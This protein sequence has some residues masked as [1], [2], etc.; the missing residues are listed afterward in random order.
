MTSLK[1]R[2]FRTGPTLWDKEDVTHYQELLKTNPEWKAEFDRLKEWGDQ[3]IRQPLDVPTHAIE[4]DGSWAFPGFQRGYKNS[5]GKW[6]WKWKLMSTLLKR[7]KDSATLGILYQLSGDRKYADYSKQIL[8][9]LVDAYGYQQQNPP[10]NMSGQD[11]F[12]PYGFDGADSSEFLT[13]ACNGY[14]LIYNLPT[15]SKQDREQIEGKL[16]RPLAERLNQ[17]NLKRPCSHS[18]W[19]P[20]GLY[21]VFI[22]GMVLNDPKL[23]ND[24]LYGQGGS[25]EKVG[26][27]LV[28]CFNPSDVKDDGH[29][30]QGT[31]L[32]DQLL[33]LTVMVRVAEVMW[34]RGVDL[35][36]YQSFAL[37]RLFDYPLKSDSQDPLDA[38]M[39]GADMAALLKVSGVNTYEYAFR[40]YRDPRYLSI[41]GKLPK[42]I[43]FDKWSYLPSLFDSPSR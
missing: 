6:I 39:I 10:A 23:A 26:D 17:G 40:R 3:R 37:K 2:S 32:D 8:L 25:M 15:I 11:H 16:I 29:W 36:S 1:P 14:D 42:N 34:H 43:T 13:Q 21:G 4:T 7:V 33:A 35:Y 18:K 5:E 31:T 12:E 24:A 27:G 41:I 30:G 38:G 19:G 9:A 22:S 28:D 20:I